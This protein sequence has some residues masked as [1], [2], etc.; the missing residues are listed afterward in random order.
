MTTTTLHHMIVSARQPPVT[1]CLSM[2]AE[3]QV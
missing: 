2:A 3:R 1:L